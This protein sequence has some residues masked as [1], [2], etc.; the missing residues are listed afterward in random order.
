MREKGVERNE[1][2]ISRGGRPFTDVTFCDVH[3]LTG[4]N[5]ARFADEETE[6]QR[7]EVICP[8]ATEPRNRRSRIRFQ[9]K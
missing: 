7:G 6:S 2:L 9:A 5:R 8:K 3:N 4:D 1:T